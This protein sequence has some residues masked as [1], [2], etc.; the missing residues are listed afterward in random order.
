VSARNK[1]PLVQPRTTERHYHWTSLVGLHGIVSSGRIEPSAHR[2]FSPAVWL[3]TEDDQLDWWINTDDDPYCRPR[4]RLALDLPTGMANS[5]R[6]LHF[7]ELGS[8]DDIERQVSGLPA[9]GD[10]WALSLLEIPAH[11]IVRIMFDGTQYAGASLTE[12]GLN[13]QAT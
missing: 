13:L 11:R 12:T 8:W 10:M 6:D 3:T 7:A 2:P 5:V 4:M 9:V 1:G